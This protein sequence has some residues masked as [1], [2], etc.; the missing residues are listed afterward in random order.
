MSETKERQVLFL[1]TGNSARSQM[2]EALLRARGGGRFVVFS[3]G[4]EPKP[5]H[6]L[7]RRVMEEAGVSLEGQVSKGVEVYLGKE[8]FHHV[9]VV[10][11]QARE[12]CPRIYPWAGEVL[13][14]PFEDPA[15]AAGSEEE[16]LQVFRR[17][18]DE[19]ER[20][21]LSWLKETS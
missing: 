11:E 14:W 15:A 16:R 19:I 12:Q 8:S 13:Y 21:I 1:C 3:A 7:T 17:V 6:P 20:K 5:I 9:I 10:C 2:A 18:R 4:L